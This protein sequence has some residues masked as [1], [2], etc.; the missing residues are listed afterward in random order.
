MKLFHLSLGLFLL[1]F[2]PRTLD[3]LLLNDLFSSMADL[4]LFCM[5]FNL[6]FLALSMSLIL[7]H[8]TSNTLLQLFL[9]LLH[10]QLSLFFHI[11]LNQLDLQLSL[12]N[13]HL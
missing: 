8:L 12:V 11:L 5:S 10:L 3:K 7:D 9:L 6:D 2:L 4:R 1:S 13:S